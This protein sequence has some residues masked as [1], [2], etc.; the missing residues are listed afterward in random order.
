[1]QNTMFDA[2]VLLLC[3]GT[4]SSLC[5]ALF[6]NSEGHRSGSTVMALGGGLAN[7]TITVCDLATL[8]NSSSTGCYAAAVLQQHEASVKFALRPGAAANDTS[9]VAAWRFRA[10]MSYV[11][12]AAKLFA[13]LLRRSAH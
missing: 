7:A 4:A 9:T 10:C 12:G 1:M 3:A 8:P 11:V 5:P 2:A 6:W 13:E